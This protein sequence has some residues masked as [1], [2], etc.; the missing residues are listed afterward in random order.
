MNNMK[1]TQL[2]FIACVAALTF[3]ACGGNDA[4]KAGDAQD[5]AQ[6]GQG[7]AAYVIDGAA[8]QLQWHGYKL[9]YGH[10]G[11]IKIQDGSLSVENGNV[12]AGNFTI[13]MKTIEETGAPDAQKAKDLAGHLMSA[14]FFDV[15]K[16]PTATFAV[17]G[18]TAQATDSTTH[19]I[20]GNLTI[21]G[22]SKNI[23]FPA[24]VV[25]NGDNIEA[26]ASFTI[27]RND[28]GVTYGTGLSGAVGDKI[29]SE[30]IDYK[31]SLKGKK[32]GV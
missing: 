17:T 11:L 27:N 28:W 24:K 12:T 16:H 7:A 8:S 4:T 20:K 5:V 26:T 22:V 18:S 19:L 14:D 32:Q 6:A 15:E 13:D 1:T 25:L 10:T 31:V 2:F 9:A 23:E 30:N 21:K 29:I 3:T